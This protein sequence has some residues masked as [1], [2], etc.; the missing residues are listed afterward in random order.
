MPNTKAV[1]K[2]I[3]W[4]I[5]LLLVALIWGGGFVITKI[6][7][8]V[9]PPMAFL[10]YRFLLAGM[11]MVIIFWQKIKKI[12]F[13]DIF[14]G[15][16]IGVFLTMGFLTQT[17]GIM[18][19][20]PAKNSFITGL[21]V[22]FV[23]FLVWLIYK[24]SPGKKAYILALVAFVGMGMLSLNFN[25]RFLLGI[26]DFLTLICA[27]FYACQIISVGYFAKKTDAIVITTVQI[28]FTGIVCMALSLI[29][30]VQP[31]VT[32][33]SPAIWAGMLYT[34]LLSTLAAFLVQNIAQRKTPASHAAIILCLESVF[35]AVVSMIFYG[36]I[37]TT[38]MIIGC[39]LILIA[40]I[41]NEV[42]YKWIFSR[43][44]IG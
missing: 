25:E 14:N 12:K 5:S 42:D 41:I 34:A 24:K 31:N 29:F 4:D 38:K 33:W 30:E 2:T 21:N 40:I 36:E 8:N 22:V 28:V 17:I 3:M 15:S 6:C 7:V 9:M 43:K 19:T 20:T 37:L 11:I 16:V 44:A 32:T 26:G 1:S 35:G 27:F 13:Q 18:Y 39:T 23:P 10:G